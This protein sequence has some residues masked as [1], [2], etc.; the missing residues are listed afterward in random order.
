MPKAFANGINIHYLQSGKGFDVVLLHGLGG[1]LAVWFL[2]LVDQLRRD[3]R[4]TACDLRGHGK[5]DMPPTGYTTDNMAED[6]RGLLD[7][8]GMEKVHLVGHSWGA[9]IA[10]HFTILY[11]ERVKKLVAIEP[12]IAALIDWRKSKEWEGWGY[13]AKRLEEFDIHVPRDKWHDADYMLRQTV[14]IPLRYGPFKGRPRRN[15]SIIDLLDTTTIIK[16]YE[17]VAGMTLDKVE[18]ISRP[19][20]ALYGEHSHFLITYEYL[21]D[22]IPNC[23]TVLIPGGDHY[24]PLEHPET[25]VDH[26]RTFFQSDV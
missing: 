4:F 3:F 17:K 13:W 11:P 26:L 23:K 7:A 15:K 1:N 25:I 5:S 6:L 12:N 24:G 2:K 18:K 14:K 8:L 19:T 21:R 20:L 9:D 16:D 22:N 10:M